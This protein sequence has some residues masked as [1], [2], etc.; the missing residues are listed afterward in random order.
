MRLEGYRAYFGAGSDT[1]YVLDYETGQRRAAVLADVEAGAKLADALTNID[2]HMSLAL[3]SDVPAAVYDRCA[4][5]A[6]VRNTVKPIVV[7]A[8]DR[9][10][11]EDILEMCYLVAGDEAS[12]FTNPSV[13]LYGEYT[14][15]LVHTATAL[16]K[17]LLASE[18][19]LPQYLHGLPTGRWNGA[20]H[21]RRLACPGDGRLFAGN[22]S[23]Q[24]REAWNAHI[25]G[26]RP[27]DL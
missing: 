8:T 21:F 14:S 23:S 22:D 19:G 3:A 27:F 15:P 17:L 6:M 16:S 24:T 26:G 4:F 11:L 2:F 13:I 1:P 12:F 25:D 18:L 9:A 7:T 20:G 5:A 10:S